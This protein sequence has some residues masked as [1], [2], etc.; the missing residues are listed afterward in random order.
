[1]CPIWPSLTGKLRLALEP[2]TGGADPEERVSEYFT[3]KV[4][5][6]LYETLIAPLYGGLYGSDPADMRVGLS[7]IHVLREF[8]VPHTGAAWRSARGRRGAVGVAAPPERPGPE[9][10][11]DQERMGAAARR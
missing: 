8:G 10:P 5:R 1:M 6:E 2:L 9:R 3:R 4:G 11:G 7:L